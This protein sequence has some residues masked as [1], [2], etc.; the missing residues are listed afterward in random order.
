MFLDE[1]RRREETQ[2][3]ESRLEQSTKDY[4]GLQND[5]RI[6]AEE[7]QHKR[8]ALKDLENELRNKAR[9]HAEQHAIL[10]HNT[11]LTRAEYQRLRDELDRLAYTLRF[12]VEEELKIY[13]ALLNSFQRKKEEQQQQQRLSIGDSKHRQTATTTTR[14]ID[15]I[16]SGGESMGFQRSQ[17]TL[18][19]TSRIYTTQTNIDDA[20]KYRPPTLPS[21]SET[22]RIFTTQTNIDDSTKY[23]PPPT[24]FIKESTITTTTTTKATKPQTDSAI[25]IIR[26]EQVKKFIFSKVLN[27]FFNIQI[28]KPSNQWT[29]ETVTSGTTSSAHDEGTDRDRS[30]SAER[31]I[32]PARTD[33]DLYG[34]VQ[35][36][37]LD[38]NRTTTTT[39]RTTRRVGH[40]GT[41]QGQSTITSNVAE[42]DEK[43][44]Q[45]K[46]HISRKYKGKI[47]FFSILIFRKILF[48]F[49][50]RKYS[51]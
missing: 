9:K 32:V 11:D 30:R 50:L 14:Y 34:G 51:Y 19:E 26:I 42:L 12:S 18:S 47:K 15:T 28:E 31:T 39:T 1:R 5:Y 13:E 3:F 35:Q 41:G 29:Y 17:P 16:S 44:L 23:R 25:P 27:F 22:S 21:I 24:P 48:F 2:R 20:F 10:E 6:L 46:I 43:L 37:L 7:I 4:D 40:G 45:S 49:F 36:S 33:I 8:R 38:Q